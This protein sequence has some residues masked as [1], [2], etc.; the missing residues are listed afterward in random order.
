MWSGKG[1]HQSPH[2]VPWLISISDS[3][4]AA[5][6]AGRCEAGGLVQTRKVFTAHQGLLLIK[7]AQS[8]TGQDLRRIFLTIFFWLLLIKGEYLE[9]NTFPC[10][11][12]HCHFQPASHNNFKVIKT[13]LKSLALA[14]QSLESPSSIDDV[15]RPS[16]I[17]WLQHNKNLEL[18]YHDFCWTCVCVCVTA[19]SVEGQMVPHASAHTNSPHLRPGIH[20]DVPPLQ[21]CTFYQFFVL[22]WSP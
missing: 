6:T 3:S 7:F 4:N 9:N 11:Y 12:I 18:F 5:R 21:P 1:T 14:L 19:S 8:L 17:G 10:R 13:T 22:P 16:D 20:T 15:L 2:T